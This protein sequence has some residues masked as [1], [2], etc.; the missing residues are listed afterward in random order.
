MRADDGAALDELDFEDGS[1]QD[2]NDG[3]RFDIKLLMYPRG[4][5]FFVSEKGYFGWISLAAHAGDIV[6]RFSNSNDFPVLLYRAP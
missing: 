6:S 1:R 3:H 5:R 2:L 4:R